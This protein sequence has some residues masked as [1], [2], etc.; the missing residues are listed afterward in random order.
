MAANDYAVVVAIQKYRNATALQALEGP[1]NDADDFIGWLKS[2]GAVPDG[3]IFPYYLKSDDK[4]STPSQS[5][6][7]AK[8]TEIGAL[9]PQGERVGR[10]IYIFLAGHGVGVDMDEVGLLTVEASSEADFTVAGAKAANYY[11]KNAY[12]DEVVLFMDCCRPWDVEVQAHYDPT[13][14]R[15]SPYAGEVRRFMAFASQ[16]GLPARERSIGGRT[17]GVFS[18]ALIDGL[19]GAAANPAGAVTTNSLRAYLPGAMQRLLGTKEKQ[20]AGYGVTDDIEFATG[21]PVQLATVKVSMSP[22]ILPLTVRSGLDRSPIAGS[23]LVTSGNTFTFKVPAFMTYIIQAGQPGQ[24][25]FREIACKVE[26]GSYD[27]GL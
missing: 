27:A 8:M 15:A 12:F 25:G 3:N 20:R 5:E 18:R 7:W 14:R 11:S 26:D 23:E 13:K 1:I 9:A 16:F 19:K 22:P 24:Q 2:V 21:L 6:V 4:A 10:R 17:N